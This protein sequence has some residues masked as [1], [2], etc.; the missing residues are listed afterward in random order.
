LIEKAADAGLRSI[1]VG[2]ESLDLRNLSQSNKRQNLNQDYQRVINRLHNLGIMINASFVFGL[3][4]DDSEVF[5][6]T[7][8]WAID[9]GV[10]T[11]T[12]HIATPYPGT[13]YYRRMKRE[14]R[15]TTSDWDHYDTRHVTFR[16]LR[17][18]SDDLQ[19]GYHQA[20]QDFYR[21]NAIVR[22]SLHHGSLKHQLKHFF[23]TSGWKKF[24][25]LWNLVIQMRHLRLMTPLLEGVLSKVSRRKVPPITEPGRIEM[26]CHANLASR[27]TL[28]K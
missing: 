27:T 14:G 10:T 4:H 5:R 13:A 7:V 2:F 20:Y 15:L 16:P 28:K 8:D 25:P 21:W 12:F 3:D 23:Y 17:M 11:A 19:N 22:A 1:F 26:D 24:E 6:R 9:Q 18:S